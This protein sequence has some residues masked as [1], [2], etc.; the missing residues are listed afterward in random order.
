MIYAKDYES[1]NRFENWRKQGFGYFSAGIAL[2][3]ESITVSDTVI[4]CTSSKLSKGENSCIRVFIT[5]EDSDIR[6]RLDGTSPT[7]S[8][9]HKL[10][11][12]QNLTIYNLH[13]IVNFKAIRIS[14]DA[15]IKVTYRY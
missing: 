5:V 14:T 7:D 9:G 2:D 15:V 4:G 11:E 8:E 13:D 6:Y 12:G 1:D 3:Y 10:T